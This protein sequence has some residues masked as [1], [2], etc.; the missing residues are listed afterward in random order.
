MEVILG[1]APQRW[2]RTLQRL[3]QE[4]DR[5]AI[6]IDHED[7]TA[8][9]TWSQETWIQKILEVDATQKY[10][11][12]DTDALMQIFHE[13]ALT[14]WNRSQWQL[15]LPLKNMANAMKRGVAV[16]AFRDNWQM[17]THCGCTTGVAKNMWTYIDACLLYTSP[18]PRD[19]ERSRMPS[20][21]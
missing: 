3:W 7:P 20:S 5:C 18:S 21:A 19:T 6:E 4:I 16:Q 9:W 13:S 1:H 10:T 17:S 15:Y 8:K 12:E 2:T 14:N 11:T